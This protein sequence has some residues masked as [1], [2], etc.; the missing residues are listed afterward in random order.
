MLKLDLVNSNWNVFSLQ[1]LFFQFFIEK[2][3]FQCVNL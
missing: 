3:E 1:K 2:F